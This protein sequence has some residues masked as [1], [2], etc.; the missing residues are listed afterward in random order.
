MDAG[1]GGN[2]SGAMAAVLGK[3]ANEAE[4]LA[5]QLREGGVLLPVNYNCPG[6]TV[7]RAIRAGS[8]R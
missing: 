6:Q 8:K 7:V 3:T 5:A 1:G 4:Q 2:H